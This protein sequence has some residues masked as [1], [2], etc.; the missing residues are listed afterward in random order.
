MDLDDPLVLEDEDHNVQRTEQA[1]NNSTVVSCGIVSYGIVW[2]RI[3]WYG[4]GR[5]EW[6]EGAVLVVVG[7]EE[8]AMMLVGGPSE[9]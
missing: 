6:V 4:V 1:E 3:V 7:R 2:Y 9:A 8:P 5:D